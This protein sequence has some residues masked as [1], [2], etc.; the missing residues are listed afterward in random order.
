[1]KN[2]DEAGFKPI[3]AAEEHQITDIWVLFFSF[4]PCASRLSALSLS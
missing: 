1:M 3:W 2:A 4:F